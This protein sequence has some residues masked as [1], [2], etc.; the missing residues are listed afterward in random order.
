MNCD[1]DN[2]ILFDLNR[3]DEILAI[4]I[5]LLI[6]QNY[7]FIRFVDINVVLLIQ[8]SS[9]KSPNGM[10]WCILNLNWK[11]CWTRLTM[12]NSVVSIAKKWKDSQLCLGVSC[13]RKD[14]RLNGI[15]FKNYHKMLSKITQH[16]RH[17]KMKIS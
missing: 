2:M 7:L 14:H 5:N 12:R 1:N 17:Q 9:M 4:Q 15:K 11:P 13:K 10:R 6:F 3:R 16:F 8:K